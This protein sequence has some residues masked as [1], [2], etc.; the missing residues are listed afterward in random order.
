MKDKPSENV[1]ECPLNL[2]QALFAYNFGSQNVNTTP[3]GKIAE[4]PELIIRD[5]IVH[6][7]N[8]FAFNFIIL[9]YCQKNFPDLWYTMS[10]THYRHFNM[11]IL[12]LLVQCS[13]LPLSEG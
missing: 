10:D 2:G 8:L 3:T 6:A 9:S 7:I 11:N 13:S 4:A 12:S 5:S 1:D